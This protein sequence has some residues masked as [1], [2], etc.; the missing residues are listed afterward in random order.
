[1]ILL[2]VLIQHQ[3]R[4]EEMTIKGFMRAAQRS[5]PP[6]MFFLFLDATVK[7]DFLKKCKQVGLLND[8]FEEIVD[9]LHLIQ[10]RL[11][12]DTA[13]DSGTEIATFLR[14]ETSSNLLIKQTKP[15]VHIFFLCNF[16]YLIL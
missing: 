3:A 16:F 9:K 2:T 12:C 1:M 11:L 15:K 13:S 7:I 5:F 6:K 10:E 4:S 8:L 14:A